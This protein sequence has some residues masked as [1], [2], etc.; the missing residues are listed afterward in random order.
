MSPHYLTCELKVVLLLRD[1]GVVQDAEV[2]ALVRRHRDPR[3]GQLLQI[4]T[5]MSHYKLDEISHL[6]KNGSVNEM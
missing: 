6:I 3:R 5:F 1:E 2:E 4:V